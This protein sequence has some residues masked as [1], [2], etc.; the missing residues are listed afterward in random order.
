M[1]I[2]LFDYV[3]PKEHIAQVPAEPRDASKLLVLDRKTKT[4]KH[5]IFKQ[6]IDLLGANDVLVINESKVF[7]A[8]LFGKK[9]SGQFAELLL[10]RPLGNNNWT[11]IGRPNLKIRQKIV[12]NEQSSA[13]VLAKTKSGELEIKITSTQNIDDLID[14]QGHTPIP[15]YID[16]SLSEADLRKKYQTVYAKNRGSAAAPTA[17]LHFTAELLEKLVNK[18]VQIEKVTLHVGLGT[19][20]NLRPENIEAKKLHQEFYEVTSETADRLNQAKQAGKR[21]IAVGTTSARTLES[22]V[23]NGKIQAGSNST[24][25]FIFPPYQLQFV[26]ALITN[27]HLPKSS[28]L[29]L[30]SSL[31]SYPQTAD[32][33]IS[34]NQSL[35]G[36]AYQEAISSNYRFFSFG[37]AMFIQ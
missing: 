11:A 25:L 24:Q 13:E 5:L 6:I 20:Q 1:D 9:D 3:L 8:R 26:D 15:P 14:K 33:F 28:L 34:F 10:L 23:V 30:V 18:G 12:F 31:V 29:M 37:D 16:S 17:G 32:K 7:P 19:F 4:F 27:F 22:A 36:Q 21:I 35:V 2:A